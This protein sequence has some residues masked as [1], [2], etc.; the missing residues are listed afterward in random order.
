[1]PGDAKQ[2]GRLLALN[3]VNKINAIKERQNAPQPQP[4][5][6]EPPVIETSPLVDAITALVDNKVDLAPLI[7]AIEATKS[8]TLNIG[9]IVKAISDIELKFDVDLSAVAK[10]IEAVAKRPPVDTKIIAGKLDNLVN[11][12]DKNTEALLKLV[13]AARSTKT[14]IYDNLGRITEI[15]LK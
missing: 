5:P 8:E 6:S 12:M 7:E 4:Q 10:Q 15:K 11:S 1:M 13:A 3:I 2:T 14:V 9:P